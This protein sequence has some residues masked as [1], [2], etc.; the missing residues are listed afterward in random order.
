MP[1]RLPVTGVVWQ[2]RRPDAGVPSTSASSISPRRTLAEVPVGTDTAGVVQWDGR[3]QSGHRVP[4]GLYFAR[5][6]SGPQHANAR[7]VLL[8]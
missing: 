7:I 6:T 1:S 8:P 5:L 2:G 4:A 3:D